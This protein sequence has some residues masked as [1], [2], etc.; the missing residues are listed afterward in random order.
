MN[1]VKPMPGELHE[2]IFVDL[3]HV[4]I[5]TIILMALV[6]TIAV[7][8]GEKWLL[9]AIIPMILVKMFQQSRKL[10]LL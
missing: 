8:T 2:S 10:F 6:H 7:V 1:M 4:I 3:L 5:R 9:I